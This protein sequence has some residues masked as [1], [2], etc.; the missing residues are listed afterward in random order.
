MRILRLQY[1]KG[2][3]RLEGKE[4]G[5]HI[6]ESTCCKRKGIGR[7]IVNYVFISCSVK[8]H[9]IDNKVNIE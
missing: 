7:G 5:G 6:T 8:E 1:L 9:F 3:R 4:K 2:K